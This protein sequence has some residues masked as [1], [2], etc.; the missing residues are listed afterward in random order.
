[1]LPRLFQW[2]CWYVIFGISKVDLVTGV[3]PVKRVYVLKVTR[4]V[5]IVVTGTDVV[6]AERLDNSIDHSSPE[7]APVDTGVTPNS[8]E[9][10]REALPNVSSWQSGSKMVCHRSLTNFRNRLT[11]S[12]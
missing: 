7:S 5:V 8:L 11:I 3:A 12:D 1:M 2:E 6:V 10:G 9:E 4:N